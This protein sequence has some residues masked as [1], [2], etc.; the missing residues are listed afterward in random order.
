MTPH[1][2]SD[3]GSTV[4]FCPVCSLQVW[5]SMKR[6]WTRL[7]GAPGLSLR[8][9]LRHWDIMGQKSIFI[10][11]N[12][13]VGYSKIDFWANT[14]KVEIKKFWYAVT[15]AYIPRVFQGVKLLIFITDCTTGSIFVCSTKKRGALTCRL[16]EWHVPYTAQHHITHGRPM[17]ELQPQLSSIVSS[18]AG[19]RRGMVVRWAPR[20]AKPR[21]RTVLLC[22]AAGQKT[23]CEPWL[24]TS[25]SETVPSARGPG[26]I[27]SPV[28][29]QLQSPRRGPEQSCRGGELG[30]DTVRATER[31]DIHLALI[32]VLSEGCDHRE[33]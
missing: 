1:W 30:Q 10:V 16:C 25:A 29:D 9:R 26:G 15:F 5:G 17:A 11:V 21:P 12:Y 27:I 2:V 6:P 7:E 23:D 24:S 32:R 13:K 19:V 33:G 4:M 20:R 14:L 31:W 28:S 18:A 22:I 8:S 3:P